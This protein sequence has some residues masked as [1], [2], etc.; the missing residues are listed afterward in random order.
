M[1]RFISTLLAMILLSNLYA[2]NSIYWFPTL[3]KKLTH[4]QED[5]KET[6]AIKN[7]KK[8]LFKNLK[9]VSRINSEYYQ[10]LD[11]NNTLFYID[12]NGKK[13]KKTKIVIDG[14]CGVGPNFACEIKDNGKEYMIMRETTFPFSDEKPI[15]NEIIGTIDKVGIKKIYFNN[16]STTIKYDEID[17][18]R[19]YAK[20]YPQTVIVEKNNQKGIFNNKVLTFYDEIIENGYWLFKV[21][22]NGKI[23]YHG[24]TQI[25][26]MSLEDFVFQLAKFKLAN[27]KTG[28][29]DTDGKEYYD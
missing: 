18:N 6:F 14:G 2:Q 11:E 26:Y 9:F 4:F 21:K 1:K 25:K 5:D 27:G 13:R 10:V 22:L 28:Y 3:G 8:I 19:G 20:R 17:A 15:S 12:I 16:D 7:K 23:G 24:V 29:V